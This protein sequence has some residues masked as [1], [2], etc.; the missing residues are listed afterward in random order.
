M[1]R[2]LLMAMLIWK[3]HI[4][5]ATLM[6][7]SNAGELPVSAKIVIPEG[8]DPAKVEVWFFTLYYF[9]T[10]FDLDRFCDP[11]GH[12][13]CHLV[14]SGALKKLVFVSANYS[15]VQVLVITFYTLVDFVMPAFGIS[16]APDN[17]DD[18]VEQGLD[19]E[20]NWED[21]HLPA[22]LPVNQLA[23]P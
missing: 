20:S 7:R 11:L 8:I 5:R 23:C 21:I 14:T 6:L 17:E 2:K 3:I 9:V 4:I 1:A 16:L 13:L 15:M 12:S 19:R 22:R 10:Q 18:V